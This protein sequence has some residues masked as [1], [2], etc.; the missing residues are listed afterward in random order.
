MPD[1]NVPMPVDPSLVP[2]AEYEA[3]VRPYLARAEERIL[4]LERQVALVPGELPC[5]AEQA[6]RLFKHLQVESCRA[7]VEDTQWS[8]FGGVILRFVIEDEGGS[9][10]VG[11]FFVRLAP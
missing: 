3:H 4:E 7:T 9:R 8:F 11:R 10:P 2:A 5:S 1:L 6:T